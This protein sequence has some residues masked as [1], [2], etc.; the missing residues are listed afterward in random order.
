MLSKI[1]QVVAT[2]H[3][4]GLVHGD[5]TTSNMLIRHKDKAVVRIN[6]RV[7]TMRVS[8]LI[9]QL[10]ILRLLVAVQYKQVPR[11]CAAGT[12]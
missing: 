6:N 1:G 8:V 12:Q 9:M 2:L 7:Q 11:C 5:L 10:C 4:G 3:D